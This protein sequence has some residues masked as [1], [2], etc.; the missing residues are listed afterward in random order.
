[1]TT[2]ASKYAA[3][4]MAWCVRPCFTSYESPVVSQNESDCMTNC[5]AKAFETHQHF[6]Y[7]YLKKAG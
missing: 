2:E 4:R 7:A 3:E 1:M 5:T 6:Y